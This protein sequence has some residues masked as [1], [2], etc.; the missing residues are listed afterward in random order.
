MEEYTY[1]EKLSEKIGEAL[2]SNTDNIGRSGAISYRMSRIKLLVYNIASAKCF[3]M[4]H[5]VAR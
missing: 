3:G 1:E 5:W 4:Y 2:C